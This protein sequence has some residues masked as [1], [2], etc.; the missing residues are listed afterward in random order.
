MTLAAL[1]K[2]PLCRFFIPLVY[3]VSV[4]VCGCV[5]GG[6]CGWVGGVC[7]CVG[8]QMCGL[9]D[10]WMECVGVLVCRCVGWW[11]KGLMITFS[12]QTISGQILVKV[13]L[14]Q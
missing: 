1:C 6:E 12:N 7:R 8:V 13:K 11:S 4:W 9:V 5:G 10:G 2:S 3:C 14:E